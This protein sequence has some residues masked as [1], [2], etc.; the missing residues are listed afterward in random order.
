MNILVICEILGDIQF[1]DIDSGITVVNALNKL[2]TEE[3]M[4]DVSYTG[5]KLY[6]HYLALPAGIKNSLS[7]KNL[8]SANGM[9]EFTK[10]VSDYK[11]HLKVIKD[12]DDSI[13]G[14]FF[15]IFVLGLLM[16]VGFITF[17]YIYIYTTNIGT[18]DGVFIQV[19]S[20]FFSFIFDHYLGGGQ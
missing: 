1:K 5:N 6:Q 14:N 9:L 12:K 7:G 3:T 18:P 11:E 15:I 19:V 20:S 17:H 13:K 16:V 10:D 2:L 8:L 4:V